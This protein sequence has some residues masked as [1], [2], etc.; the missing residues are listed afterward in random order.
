MPRL[1]LKLN[2]YRNEIKNRIFDLGYTLKDIILYLQNE[3]EIT[4]IFKTIQR[5]Y[6]K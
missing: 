4:I 5:R 3:Q 6:T 2:N 1:Y